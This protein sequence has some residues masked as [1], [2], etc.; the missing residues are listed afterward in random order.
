MSAPLQGV[1]PAVVTPLTPDE[2]FA[3]ESFELLLEKVYAAG[4]EGIYV[5]G[6]TGEGLSQPVAMRKS[7]AEVAVQASP[8]DKTVIVHVGA[9]R[10]AELDGPSWSISRWARSTAAACAV[11]AAGS[12]LVRARAAGFVGASDATGDVAG[13]SF[14]AFARPPLVI[15]MAR[16]LQRNERPPPSGEGP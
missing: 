6:Q 12:W 15:V 1:L 13:A 10:T 3:A 4:C 7:V 8:R 2:E 9:G 16:I 11:P 14:V 5:C